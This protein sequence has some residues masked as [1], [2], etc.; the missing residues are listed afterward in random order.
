MELKK[1]KKELGNMKFFVLRI[2]MYLTSHSK[3]ERLRK[4]VGLGKDM[5]KIL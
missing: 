1:T 3:P 2:P 4:Y 5:E